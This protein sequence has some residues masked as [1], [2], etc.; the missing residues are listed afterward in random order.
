MKKHAHRLY[1]LIDH[2]HVTKHHITGID[3]T[4]NQPFRLS[5]FNQGV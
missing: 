2:P 5:L 3:V 1:G 4:P